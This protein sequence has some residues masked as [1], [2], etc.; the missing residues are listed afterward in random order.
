MKARTKT[1]ITGGALPTCNE[2]ACEAG[3]GDCVS[4]TC[5]QGLVCDCDPVADGTPCRA[6][7]CAAGG[8]VDCVTDADCQPADQTCDQNICVGAS[9]DD[10]TQNG[11]ET[12][13]DCGGPD[14]APCANGSTCSV[15]E[16]CTSI[17]C[18]SAV[19]QPCDDQPDC[20]DFLYC[21]VDLGTCKSKKSA[22]Q[23]CLEDYECQ[24]DMCTFFG[25]GIM[26][27]N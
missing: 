16:D 3:S 13:L 7:V 18:N 17:H 14:C 12:D 26:A 2:A 9:C 19:C 6:G 22:F 15:P 25:A 27:C 4:C 10:A 23:S 11:L 21:D 1:S 20:S 24:S 5:L 8:C